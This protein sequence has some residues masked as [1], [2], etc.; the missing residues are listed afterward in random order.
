MWA[1]IG[2]NNQFLVLR[3]VISMPGKTQSPDAG[4]GGRR[5]RNRVRGMMS[6]KTGKTV[7]LA[8]IATP[9]IGYVVNDLRKPDSV[10]RGLVG[11]AVNRLLPARSKEIKEIDI[12][13]E[14][15]ILED[16][17]NTGN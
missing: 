14:V 10:I 12:T 9:I 13:D 17:R 6:S 16:N 11:R 3:E 4:A 7:S 1:G 2:C 8:S 15:E 5:F